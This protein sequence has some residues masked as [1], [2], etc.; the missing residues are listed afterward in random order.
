[1]RKGHDELAALAL[2]QFNPVLAVG[3]NGGQRLAAL[4]EFGRAELELCF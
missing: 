3:G 1:L 4:A 2:A